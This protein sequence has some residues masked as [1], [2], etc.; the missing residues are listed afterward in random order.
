MFVYLFMI[1]AT[2]MLTC[3]A[4][5]SVQTARMVDK[6]Y[7]FEKEMKEVNRTTERTTE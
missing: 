5:L 4:I 6:I 3:T 7:E 2:I 1:I